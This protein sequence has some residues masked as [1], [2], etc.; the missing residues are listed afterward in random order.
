MARTTVPGERSSSGRTP[1]SSRTESV[2]VLARLAALEEKVEGKTGEARNQPSGARL[3]PT[4][5]TSVRCY[6]VKE[7]ARILRLGLSVTYLGIVEG[8]I[9]AVKIGGRW[10]VPHEALVRFLQTS[11]TATPDR[12][13]SAAGVCR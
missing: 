8:R 5:D 6:T 4:E 11:R 3:P 7:T 1:A 9:P 2:D 13:R 12:D 10:L